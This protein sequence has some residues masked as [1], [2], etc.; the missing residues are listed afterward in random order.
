MLT[1]CISS[2]K[3]CNLQ[4]HQ[5]RHRDM[6][7]VAIILARGGSK[8]I[9]RKNVRPFM[10]QPVLQFPIKAALESGCFDEV[11]VSTDDD[12]IAAVS[13]A[14][15]AVTP[16]RRSEKNSGDHSS[17]ASALL[18]VIQQYREVGRE[19]DY[20]CGMY[21]ATPLVTARHVQDGWNLLRSNEKAETVLPVVR[22]GYPIQRAFCVRDGLLK[23]VAP[24]HEL[25]RS[26]DLPPAYHD[27]GQ[28]YWMR[29]AAFERSGKIF[30]DY[31]M[32]LVLSELDVQDIDNEDDW[33]LAE[34]KAHLRTTR[35]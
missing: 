1:R 15:G 16:F 24:E 2:R 26:Q 6:S 9:P 22:F 7:A 14:A 13:I 28:W 12:E 17:T 23:L 27:V 18:E 21:A 31:C 10:G 35:L 25:T 33:Q 11:M 34:A 32:P 19:F 8:R 20:V 5:F 30:S 3:T 29:T 4:F